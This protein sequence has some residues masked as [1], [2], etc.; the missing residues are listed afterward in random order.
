MSLVVGLG[1]AMYVCLQSEGLEAWGFG[2][3]CGVGGGGLV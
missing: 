1:N 3:L 2:P